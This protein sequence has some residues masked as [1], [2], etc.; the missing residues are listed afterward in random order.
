MLQAQQLAR[1]GKKLAAAPKLAEAIKVQNA[2]GNCMAEPK[3]QHTDISNGWPVTRSDSDTAGAAGGAAAR[4]GSGAASP[5]ASSEAIVVLDDLAGD[6]NA[7]SA[8]TCAS[9]ARAAGKENVFAADARRA[10][11]T[12]VKRALQANLPGDYALTPSRRND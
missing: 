1:A 5:Q 4:D 12:P 11:L 8:D 10:T 7:D 2:G 3:E 6:Q 9:M